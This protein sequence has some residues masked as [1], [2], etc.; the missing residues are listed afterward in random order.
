MQGFEIEYGHLPQL[1]TPRLLLRKGR[2]AD[3]KDL[4]AYSKDPQVARYVLWDAHRS[5]Q[6]SK[7]YLRYLMRQYRMGQPSSYVIVQKTTQKVIGTIGFMWIQPEYASAEVGYSLARECWNQGYMTEALGALLK[8][9]FEQLG[10]NRIEAQ[11]DVR[12]PSS[13]VVMEHVGMVKEGTLRARMVN[14][15]EYVDVNLYAILRRDW[16]RI[17]EVARTKPMI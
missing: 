1:E 4:Y 15:Q 10:L 2:M 3:A 8:F 14:K 6:E 13:G 7:A 11:H 9:A 17:K 16:E 5:I 12:N